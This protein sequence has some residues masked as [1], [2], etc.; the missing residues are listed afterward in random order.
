MKAKELHNQ[1]VAELKDREQELRKEL[2]DLSFQHGTRQLM[3][4][5]ALRRKRREVAVVLT[6]LR[7][8]EIEAALSA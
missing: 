6:V 3:D 5:A 4:T 2:F 1:T 7:Q 8:K